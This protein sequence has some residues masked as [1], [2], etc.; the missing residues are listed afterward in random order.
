MVQAA[1]VVAV[2]RNAATE[3]SNNAVTRWWQAGEPQGNG[4]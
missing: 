4:G 3:G 1:G 2:K